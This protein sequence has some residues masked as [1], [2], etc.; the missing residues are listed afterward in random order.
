MGN[1]VRPVQV[2]GPASELVRWP[3][4]LWWQEDEIEGLARVVRQWCDAVHVNHDVTPTPVI[5]TP[6]SAL[7]QQKHGLA[8]QARPPRQHLASVP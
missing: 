8:S 6:P 7:D 4:E 5:R 2:E 3:P 1:N